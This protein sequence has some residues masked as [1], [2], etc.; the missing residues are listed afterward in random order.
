[1]LIMLVPIAILTIPYLDQVLAFYKA[2]SDQEEGMSRASSCET[3]NVIL[4]HYCSLALQIA[5]NE[6]A[7][8]KS[9]RR[10]A[11]GHLYGLM[12]NWDCGSDPRAK[13]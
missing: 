6:Q 9:S 10:V 13:N 2:E 5:A 3:A 7:A 11:V 4:S 8:S 1:M 12:T